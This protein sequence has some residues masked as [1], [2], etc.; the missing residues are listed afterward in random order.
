MAMKAGRK[1]LLR[2][3]FVLICSSGKSS[4]KVAFPWEEHYLV[5]QGFSVSLVLQVDRSSHFSWPHFPNKI[6]ILLFYLYRRRM[7]G[8]KEK[9]IQPPPLKSIAVNDKIVPLPSLRELCIPLWDS[10]AAAAQASQ[11]QHRSHSAEEGLSTSAP[12]NISSNPPR[13][14]GG[15]G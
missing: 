3:F 9:E 10:Q 8:K 1:T 2:A 13:V 14:R 6:L 7:Q 4:W 12:A 11:H 15:K 5:M